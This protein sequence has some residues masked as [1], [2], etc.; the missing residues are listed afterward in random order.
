LA[1]TS[2]TKF[3]CYLP[4][5]EL[6]LKGK[7]YKNLPVRKRFGQNFLINKNIL[8]QIADKA[9]F[10]PDDFVL[11]IGP[12]H[13]ALT[14]KLF[15]RVKQVVAVEIDRDLVEVLNQKFKNEPK[16]S[17]ISNDILEFDLNILP[18]EN[19]KF[20][21]RKAIG[22]IP[23]YITTPIIMKMIDEE[24]L[25]HHGISKTTQLFSELIIMLQKE[26]GERLLAK[27]GT[28]EYGA[29]SVICQYACDITP[30][31]IVDR[32]SYYPAPKVDS[33]VVSLKLKTEDEH[34]INSP[35]IFWRLVHGV[36]ISRR[37]TLKNSLKIAKFTE[38]QINKI[39]EKFD[40]TI[41]GETMALSSF[42]KLSNLLGLTD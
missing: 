33:I 25:K 16:I 36:F 7:N 31:L 38:Q 29:L 24:Q 30:L 35:E 17:I 22:N 13:G 14:E 41:R 18:L 10:G 19:Y 32:N 3:Y 11:E 1:D 34:Q 6:N 12:G 8:E 23:Y 4:L 2:N 20:E 15:E 42:A 5:K 37:K 40:L 9:R 39:A 26:V 28:K 21:N 27:P